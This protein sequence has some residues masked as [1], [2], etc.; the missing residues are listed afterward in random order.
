M[1]SLPKL[2][3]PQ[4][5]EISSVAILPQDSSPPKRSRTSI[6]MATQS[7]SLDGNTR[8]AALFPWLKPD[9]PDSRPTPRPDPLRPTREKTFTL[10]STDAEFENEQKILR[11]KREQYH[12]F[13]RNW[14]R[15]FY[16]S[17]VDQEEYRRGIRE[18]LK[19]QMA[20]K[21]NDYQK[22]QKEKVQE[23][24]QAFS[25]DQEC[26]N[27]DKR[28]RRNKGLYLSNFRNEN[29]KIIEQHERLRRENRINTA[30]HEQEL[31]RYNPVN[32]SQTLR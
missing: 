8:S 13:H 19:N 5:T 3:A 22:F 30:I 26:V 20:E 1:T 21:H 7:K 32:W 28:D 16:G 31:L 15:P 23:S 9:L 2:K 29:K 11:K 4:G 18:Q 17:K 14:M 10:S 25:Y 24:E 27:K 6:R 12:Q